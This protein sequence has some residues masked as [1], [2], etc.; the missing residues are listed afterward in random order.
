SRTVR[1]QIATN[2]HEETRH[3]ASGPAAVSHID[4]ARLA[5]ANSF[6]KSALLIF[7]VSSS[8]FDTHPRVSSTAAGSSRF[9]PR[10]ISACAQSSVSATPGD[11]LSARFRT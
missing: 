3:A 1:S 6:S 8:D 5:Y 11:L 4:Y 9:L 7:A 10:A 2:S